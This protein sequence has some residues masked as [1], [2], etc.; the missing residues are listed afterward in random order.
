MPRDPLEEAYGAS[1]QT[2][3]YNPDLTAQLEKA[4]GHD[5]SFQANDD[6]M[7]G[8]PIY[9]VNP[10][11]NIS[12]EDHIDRD[13]QVANGWLGNAWDDLKASL[14]DALMTTKQGKSIVGASAGLIPWANYEGPEA[15]VDMYPDR[16]DALNKQ[17]SD[18]T[19]DQVEYN[20]Q[21]AKLDTQKAEAEPLLADYKESIANYQAKIDNTPVSREYKLHQMLTSSAGDDASLFDKIKYGASSNIGSSVGYMV[22]ALIADFGSNMIQNLSKVAITNAFP[23]IGIAADVAATGIALA[24]SL[25]AIFTQR[26]LESYSEIMKPITEVRARLTAQYM[27]DHNLQSA[28]QIPEDEMRKIRNQ[29]RQGAEQQFRENSALGAT[30]IA[31]AAL[32]PF[33]NI[34]Y[35]VGNV[36]RQ[37]TKGLHIGEHLFESASE[38]GTLAHSAAKIGKLYSESVIGGYEMGFRTAAQARATQADEKPMSKEDQEKYNSWSNLKDWVMQDGYDVATSMDLIPNVS[39]SNLGG[40][41]SADKEFQESVWGG[42][43]L[44]GMMAGPLTAL[45]IAKG[46]SAYKSTLSDLQ[47]K[48]FVDVEGKFKRVQNSVMINA[49]EKGRVSQLAEAINHLANDD[50]GTSVISKEQA[51]K[52]IDDLQK[53]YQTWQSINDRVD[54]IKTGSVSG[55]LDLGITKIEFG[56]K[57]VSRAKDKVK[58]DYLN[59]ITN[60]RDKVDEET[61]LE[62]EKD[63]QYEKDRALF[64]TD[65]PEA[66]DARMDLD[67]RKESLDRVLEQYYKLKSTNVGLFGSHELLKQNIDKIS[68]EL[69]EQS[70]QL[71]ETEEN[72]QEI[73]SFEPSPQLQAI[74]DKITANQVF[75]KEIDEKLDKLNSIKTKADLLQ[76]TQENIGRPSQENPIV[77]PTQETP[78]EIQQTPQTETQATEVKQEDEHIYDEHQQML[79][80]IVNDPHTTTPVK[81]TH[82]NGY[83]QEQVGVGL[84]QVPLPKLVGLFG[85]TFHNNPDYIRNN[86]NS[87]QDIHKVF[88]PNTPSYEMNPDGSLSE[89]S[90]IVPP[91]QHDDISIDRSNKNIVSK[92]ASN[93]DKSNQG[94]KIVSGLSLAQLNILHSGKDDNGNYNDSKKDGEIAF[95]QQIDQQLVNTN[96]VKIGDVLK[97]GLDN[98][99]DGFDFENTSDANYDNVNIGVYKDMTNKGVSQS[100]LILHL[101]RLDNL[102]LPETNWDGTPFDKEAEISLLR[103][104]RRNLIQKIREDPNSLTNYKIVTKGF[105]YFNT[106]DRGVTSTIKAAI[107]DD[108]RPI[109]SYVNEN[110]EPVGILH[111]SPL[112]STGDLMSGSTILLIPN[113]TGS[114]TV[115][116][117]MYMTKKQLKGEVDK[118]G[119]PEGIYKKVIDSLTS[120]IKT[121]YWKDKEAASPYVFISTNDALKGNMGVKGVYTAKKEGRVEV[122]VGDKPFTKDNIEGFKEAL[123][124]TYININKNNIKDAAYQ[125]ELMKSPLLQTNLVANPVLLSRYNNKQGEYGSLEDN[126]HYSYFSQHTITVEPES[127]DIISEGPIEVREEN[128][129]DIMSR[130][131]DISIDTNPRPIGKLEKI[132]RKQ[133]GTT[134]DDVSTNKKNK[135]LVSPLISPSLQNEMIESLAYRLVNAERP[136]DSDVGKTMNVTKAKSWVQGTIHSYTDAINIEKK[137][138]NP[139]QDRIERATQALDKFKLFNDHI[140]AFIEKAQRFIESLGF[141]FDENTD[142]YEN[143]EEKGEEN[144]FVHFDDD[145]SRKVD[146]WSFAPKEVKKILWF[147]PKLQELNPGFAIDKEYM[148]REEKVGRPIPTYKPVMNSL[149]L[150]TFNNVRDTWEK[151]LELTSSRFF[152]S[153][154]T[155]FTNMLNILQNKSN[156]PVVQEFA[157]RLLTSHEQVKTAFFKASKL[158]KQQ[159]VTVLYDTKNSQKGGTRRF[160][161]IVPSDRRQGIRATFNKLKD[162]FLNTDTG[163]L[164]PTE[165]KVTGSRIYKVNTEFAKGIRKSV[166]DLIDNEASYRAANKT[167]RKSGAVLTDVAKTQLLQLINQVGVNMSAH[168][169]NDLLRNYR[170][171]AGLTVDKSIVRELFLNRILKRLSGEVKDTKIDNPDEE[172]VETSELKSNNPFVDEKKAMNTIASYEHKHRV[173]TQSGAYRT[174]SGDSYFAFVKPNYLSDIFTQIKDSKNLGFT[175]WIRANVKNNSFARTSIYLNGLL[176]PR[177]DMGLEL[178]YELGARNMVTGAESKLLKEMNPREHQVTKLAY[179]QNKG[180]WRSQFLYDTLSDKSTKPIVT[181]RNFDVSGLTYIDKNSI[182]LPQDALERVY[183]AHFLNEYER[184][185]D[186]INQNKTLPPHQQTKGYHSEKGMGQY[187]NVF[188]FLNKAVL[189]VDHPKMSQDMYNGDGT[190]KPITNNTKAMIITELNNH[191]NKL[192]Q[193]SK[194]DMQDLGIYDLDATTKNKFS[195]KDE[196]T[197]D[198]L[199]LL[200]H[201]YM[202]DS[203]NAVMKRLGLEGVE[204]IK[205]AQYRGDWSRVPREQLERIVDYVVADYVYNTVVN[206][207]EM[208]ILTGDPAQAGKGADR[209]TMARIRTKYEN[210]PLESKKQVLLA[211]IQSTLTN[212]NKRNASFL[213]SGEG[214]KFKESTYNLSIANDVKTNSDHLAYYKSMFGEEAA[215]EAYGDKELTDAQEMTTVKEFLGNMQAYG[216]IDEIKY[217]KALF[218]N[219]RDQY[220]EDL[221]KGLIKDIKPNSTERPELRKL[222]MQPQKPVQRT[223]NM[224]PDMKMRKE[225]YI[226]TSAYPLVPDMLTG[227]MLDF[228]N[229]MK[230]N[231]VHRVSFATGV[232]QGNA[233]A[234][235]IF[236]EDGSYNK[237]FFENNKNTLNRNGFRIQLE[238]PFD[239]GHDHVREGTQQSKLIFVDVHDSTFLSYKG[240]QVIAS[241]LKDRYID[242]HR[243]IVDIQ[244]DETMEDIGVSETRGVLTRNLRKMSNM[245]MR[246]G[247]NSG[248]GMDSLL[249]LELNKEGNFKVPLTFATN[250]GQIE[251]L[252]TAVLSNNI[253]RLKMPGGSGIQGSEVMLRTGKKGQIQSDEK[254]KD[255]RDIVWTKPEY[256]GLEK[257]G[258]LHKDADGNVM[259]AQIVMPFYFNRNG[260]RLSVQNYMQEGTNLI[261]LSKIDPELLQM[262]GFRIPFQGLNSGMWFEIVGFLP[263]NMGDLV[264]VPGEI[265]G[266]M[267]SDYDVDKLY[268][269]MYNYTHN[270]DGKISKVDSDDPQTKEELQNA[271]IDIQKSIYTASDDKIHRAVL[272]PLS[273]DDIKATVKYLGQDGRREFLGNF[274]P[275]Y[276]RDVYFS[277]KM[278]KTGCLGYG[279]KVVMYDG[280]FKEVQDIVV[281][282]MLMGPDSTP[283]YVS[284]LKRGIEQMYWV[285]QNRGMSYRVNESHILSLKRYNQVDHIKGI[286]TINIKLSDYLKKTTAFKDHCKGYKSSLIQFPNKEVPLCPYYLGLWLG[287]GSKKQ[288]S[289]ISNIDSEIRDYLEVA[290]GIH[291]VE[292]LN[293]LTMFLETGII[294]EGFKKAYCRN[295]AHFKPE[296]EK[297]MPDEY[298]YNSP[299]VRLQLLAGLIDSDGTYKPQDK[300]YCITTKYPKLRDQICYITRSLGFYTSW[301][302]IEGI[303]KEY[304]NGKTYTCQ[305]YY[306]IRFV[307]ELT[308]PVKL[309][310]KKQLVKSNF[311][312]RLVTGISIEKDTIDNYYGFEI[313]GDHLFLLEDFTVTHNT[314]ISANANTSHAMAQGSNLFVKGQGVLFLDEKGNPFNDYLEPESPVENV[315]T[316]L[317]NDNSV[318]DTYEGTYQYYDNSKEEDV[319]QNTRENGAW[320]LDKVST[321]KDPITDKTYRISDLIS[322]VLGVSVDNAKEQVLGNLGVNEVNFNTS[323]YILRSGFSPNYMG[324]F[325]NQEILK[326]YYEKVGEA[327]DIYRVDYTPNKKQAAIDSLFEKYSKMYGI[328]EDIQNGPSFEGFKL[329]DMRHWLD[330]GITAKNVR[331]Q[332]YVLKAFI[333]YKQVADGLQA[334]TSNFNIDAKGLPKNMSETATKANTIDNTTSDIPTIQGTMPGAILGNIEKYRDSTIPGIFLDVPRLATRIFMGEDNPLFAYNTESY[335]SNTQTILTKLGKNNLR[336]EDVDKINTHTK[337]FIYSGFGNL[338]PDQLTDLRKRLVFD[339]AGNESIQ[340]RLIN[341]KKRF[342]RN[343]FLQA[344]REVGSIYPDNPK[345]VEIPTGSDEDY[346]QKTKEQWISAIYGDDPDLAIFA[347]DLVKYAIYV[348]PQEYGQSNVMKYVPGTYLEDIGFYDYLHNI[349]NKLSDETTLNHFPDQFIQHLPT[350]P[351]TAK[352]DD[353]GGVHIP[354]SISRDETRTITSFML[355][356]LATE[357]KDNPA[358]SLVRADI[359]GNKFYPEYLSVFNNKDIGKQIYSGMTNT[360][361]TVSYIRT[362]K[363]GTNG[364]SEYSM[365]GLVDT[366]IATQ[367]LNYIVPESTNETILSHMGVGMPENL[368]EG[369]NVIDKDYLNEKN[370]GDQILAGVI[371]AD[372]DI[373][374]NPGSTQDN[375]RYAKLYQWLAKQFQYQGLDKVGISL[376]NDHPTAGSTITNGKT[377]SIIFN[378]IKTASNKSTGLSSE[379]EKQRVILHE[380]THILLNN[381]L[382]T[383]KDTPEYKAV[384]DVWNAY[385]D[386]IYKDKETINGIQKGAFDAELF[387]L[388]KERFDDNRSDLDGGDFLRQTSAILNDPEKLDGLLDDLGKNLAELFKQVKIGSANFDLANKESAYSKQRYESFKEHMVKDF[389]G[390]LASMKNKYYS[391][392][393]IQEFVPETLTN[394]ELQDELKK[395]PSLW[396][397]L[398][399]GIKNL[400]ASIFGTTTEEKTLLDDAFEAVFNF[401]KPEKNDVS[402]QPEGTINTPETKVKGINISTR[403]DDKLGRALTNPTWSSMKDGANYFD[404]ESSYKRM[405]SKATDPKEALRKDMNTMYFLIV[406]K[407]QQNPE[408]VHQITERGGVPFLE[409]SEHTIGVKDSRWEGKGTDSNFIKVLIE[410][411]K[412]QMPK[413]TTKDEI[414][415]QID[416]L[417]E[418]GFIK[419]PC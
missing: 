286:E 179:F 324:A 213:A 33:S 111:A 247:E 295:V 406:K 303:T 133:E 377:S 124:E 97:V 313:D 62:T 38:L 282:D 232:K 365:N 310:R 169:L 49:F 338:S 199:D 248:F 288:A 241:E 217:T 348:S 189:D 94:N 29:S 6:P 24:T 359:K 118:N 206:S 9:S 392:Y 269:Y 52:A 316:K 40:K 236:N 277:N 183:N 294:N 71:D 107:G 385:K 212:L 69:I 127:Q 299:E 293:D 274:D 88:N 383:R 136:D 301:S 418:Q 125:D 119:E 364:I 3:T 153:N 57:E 5:N 146:P 415:T 321:F 31:A 123:G 86:F 178:S 419:K 346:V 210:N 20:T 102:Q 160:T 128:A 75:Q 27:Q 113:E 74:Y 14:Y 28:D 386:N 47:D 140:D 412:N 399:N 280:S 225:F 416:R 143:L 167:D 297:Y 116:V 244:K 363:M 278:G 306:I 231:D 77:T 336:Q 264:I 352:V 371:K 54:N 50:S 44:A 397:R 147:I 165:D 271:L 142:Y 209:D 340:T 400:L 221:K 134:R 401:L 343:E 188:F 103:A 66:L 186:I 240:T 1:S 390:N 68:D 93:L 380:M 260:K 417:I 110:G 182:Q 233:G 173:N 137:K 267:G 130:F 218:V 115:Y 114:E 325:I 215:T 283:R 387:K 311:K 180:N 194:K 120:Y 12:D 141:K 335:K 256:E 375:R 148:D 263:H 92:E 318:K 216:K 30:D 326:E 55:K 230:A 223:N 205:D 258:Y 58:E 328:K 151:I 358:Q 26:N 70:K 164:V 314:A 344:V 246:E 405:K 39:G 100:K 351:A 15:I 384:E 187:F 17:L 59:V 410:A 41:Y 48:G 176:D 374:V 413:E 22:P 152:D 13:N 368:F 329:S 226:K 317:D 56:D 122:W 362:E 121:G 322:Q 163:I 235:S 350:M 79:K 404:V 393:D 330:T 345:Q 45:S 414:D 388:L 117:P 323:L 23:E 312:N 238:V 10:K 357:A 250:V 60:L 19:I 270:E 341:L 149:G 372:N 126:Q 81:A 281:G 191:F 382:R 290:Y 239:E 395:M 332:L 43:F 184:V 376:N 203:S 170:T 78:I 2:D 342:P 337:Q 219:D 61:Q 73:R 396:D 211:N 391:Y 222:V 262:N 366:I 249:G 101:H 292:G 275:L 193:S 198:V 285:H 166:I 90:S 132:L 268:Q 72:T 300:L 361:G 131:D 237:S 331:E 172:D 161:T 208:L 99:P 158:Q 190:L 175:G 261:D 298:I 398:V 157:K 407:L 220:H 320:R 354:G 21:K 266:Q 370:N 96:F 91:S 327:D 356:P 34:G 196:L 150:P 18:K 214:G 129:E 309:T 276:Q 139:N 315:R 234:K 65:H 145:A 162:E 87:I 89:V 135:L 255:H 105:G 159:N 360:D 4:Y 291:R 197:P 389:L 252:L 98:I 373:L 245:L 7:H 227:S 411:Y 207:N 334:L 284:D 202:F 108:T 11:Y 402:L 138:E 242:Y 273:F 305:P 53:T 394:K 272:S 83:L 333:K 82:L 379:L 409:A 355:M 289:A 177:V 367:S 279:T 36:A 265:A 195:G 106:N 85:R 251:P 154:E 80:D 201:N 155:G 109:L 32:M 171:E 67:A 307:P 339:T 204:G 224:E 64:E 174:D 296:E 192:I 76:Y 257:L 8:M 104:N 228:L 243:K 168:G 381:A 229:D 408:L 46:I 403:S 200:E 308:I 253:T 35:G 112:A 347:K 369:E 302:R 42:Q 144:D 254:L 304:P 185:N 37:A 353:R 319:N 259:N 378:P 95:S 349:N 63:V 25:G 156:A 16:I 287:D 181:A 51:A 84:N